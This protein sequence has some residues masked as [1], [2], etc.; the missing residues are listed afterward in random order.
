MT[1]TSGVDVGST[2]TKAVVIDEERRIVGRAM[3][4]TGFKLAEVAE[5]A[6]RAALADA[7]LAPDGTAYVVATGFG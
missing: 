1:Y 6:H 4:P 5:E 3:L 7:G 2:Y